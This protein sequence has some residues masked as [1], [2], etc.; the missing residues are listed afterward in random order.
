MSI[1]IFPAAY[2]PHC[3]CAPWRAFITCS[4]VYMYKVGGNDLYEG[5]QQAA[6]LFVDYSNSR[7]DEVGTLHTVGGW[8]GLGGWGCC[9]PPLPGALTR[10]VYFIMIRGV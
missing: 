10:C 8:V 4:Y 2:L 6:Q 5:L 1:L 7:Y 9:P 3:S